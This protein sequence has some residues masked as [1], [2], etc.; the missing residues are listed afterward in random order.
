MDEIWKEV[1]II[2]FFGYKRIVFEFGEDLKE[3]LIEY[4][5]DS[6]KIIY[7]VYK[8]KGNI[9]RVNVNIAVIIIEE[10]RMLKEV[11]IGIYVFF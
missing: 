2:E 7:L 10:Y 6:I 11:K 1:E 9:R 5:I 3:V 4:V 8:E